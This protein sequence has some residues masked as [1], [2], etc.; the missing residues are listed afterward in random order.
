MLK[1]SAKMNN[2]LTLLV[3]ILALAMV[4]PACGGKKVQKTEG[5]TGKVTLDGA[6]LAKC[7]VYF[8]PEGE[9]TQAV[10]TTDDAG[11]YTLQTVLGA[12]G[13]GTTP[14]AY[15]VFFKHEVEVTPEVK[16]ADGEVEKEAVMKVDLPAKYLKAETSGCTAQ[17]AKG[18]NEFNFD[19]TSK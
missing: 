9:G 1:E 18:K 14:G 5:V 12:A 6:P 19:L 4:L 16:N 17:V 2:K 10:G 13:A 8:V 11:V 7:T 15:K 3:A